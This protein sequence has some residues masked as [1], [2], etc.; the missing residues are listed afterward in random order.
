MKYYVQFLNESSGRTFKDGQIFEVPKFPIDAIGSDGVFILD[1]RNSL[2]IMIND[3]K[4]RQAKFKNFIGFKIMKGE[5]FT[6]SVEIYNS[7]IYII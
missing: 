7:L 2:E 3:A 6:N 4:E 5:R 1:G